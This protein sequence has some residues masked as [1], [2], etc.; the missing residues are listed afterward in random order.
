MGRRN[1]ERRG[2]PVTGVRAAGISGTSPAIVI[3]PGHNCQGLVIAILID[4]A[5]GRPGHGGG[6]AAADDAPADAARGLV[7]KIT[8][9]LDAI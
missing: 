5:A 7:K 6:A 3:A 9:S 2:A 1:A 8:K 4:P